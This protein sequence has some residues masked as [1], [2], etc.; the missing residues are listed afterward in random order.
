VEVGE[1]AI[2]IAVQAD[3]LSKP[4]DDETERFVADVIDS[5]EVRDIDLI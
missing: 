1:G 2:R 5:I 4:I 3:H